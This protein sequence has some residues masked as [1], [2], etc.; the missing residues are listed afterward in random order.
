MRAVDLDMLFIAGRSGSGP[1][2]W[3]TRWR[4]R[5][6]QASLVEQPDWDQP[7]REVWVANVVAACRAATRPIVFLA[8]SLGVTTLVHAAGL[9]VRGQAKGAFLVAPP[10]DEGLIA[11]GLGEF[12]PCPLEPLPF[13][14]LVIAS[15]NDPYGAFADAESKAEHWGA[16]IHDAGLSGHINVESGHGPWPE[17][18][19]RLAGFLKTLS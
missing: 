7:D 19:M 17:G 18:A 4:R 12:A 16:R 10:S 1:D 5:M 8:H 11:A 9:L 13:S 14:T 3:Q 2:H 6:P 15:R